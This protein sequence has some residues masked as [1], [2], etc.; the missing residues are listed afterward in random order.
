VTFGE[1]IQEVLNYGFSQ[2]RYE[3]FVRRWLNEGLALIYRWTQLPQGEKVT[4]L[5]AP[6]GQWQLQLPPE[7]VRALAVHRVD[8]SGLVQLA[9]MPLDQARE[10]AAMGAQG[11]LPTAYSI[12]PQPGAPS[13]VLAPPPATGVTVQV[14]Y[15]ATSGEL[16][17]PTDVVL[18]PRGYERLPIYYALWRAYESEDD[19]DR[20]VYHKQLFDEGIRQLGG[21]A[22]Q[23]SVEDFREVR[24]MLDV[25]G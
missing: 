20:A 9:W 25:W 7:F 12:M 19:Q 24:G 10:V 3:P 14:R 8:S 1:A 4:A 2:A 13:L 6:A 15:R 11:A 17:N 16:T 23:T 5:D 18:V 22:H 21:D